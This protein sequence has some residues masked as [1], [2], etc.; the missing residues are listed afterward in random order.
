MDISDVPNLDEEL[1]QAK[2]YPFKVQLEFDRRFRVWRDIIHRNRRLHLASAPTPE[3]L[4]SL[5]GRYKALDIAD[6]ARLERRAAKEYADCTYNK[7]RNA[8]DAIGLRTV[9]FYR[10]AAITEQLGYQLSQYERIV[11]YR[12]KQPARVR[13]QEY[14]L[15][16][17]V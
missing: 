12:I 13:L 10:L 7:E 8:W 4:R 3:E 14:K 9:Y 6:A 16:K 1:K 15:L 5:H 17:E 11:D 2:G